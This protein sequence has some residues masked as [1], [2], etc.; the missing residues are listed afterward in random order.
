M[1][2]K[3]KYAGDVYHEE[4]DGTAGFPL[5]PA[6]LGRDPQPFMYGWCGGGLGVA[7][8]LLYAGERTG[9][10]NYRRMGVNTINF[11]VEHV[12]RDIP[13]LLFGDYYYLDK[14]WNPGR[15][16][17]VPWPDSVA[18]RQHGEN[19]DQLA[20]C[21]AWA[22]AHKMPEAEKWQKLLAEAG[23][24]LVTAERHRGMFP[25]SWF[26]DGKPAG[27]TEGKPPTIEEITTAGAYLVAPLAKLY[28]LSADKRYLDTAESALRAYYEEFGRDL[29]ISY[30]G[31]TLDA[32]AT[33]KEAGWGFMHGAIALYEVTKKQEYLDW[34]R[35]AA[36]WLLTWYVMYDMQLP[37][38][39]PLHGFVNTTGW[40]MIS[41]Q[42][43]ELDCWGQ[44]IA[45]DF[46]LLGEYLNDQRYVH[47]GR[48]LFY[49]PTQAIARP[50]AMF[51]LKMIGMELEHFNHTN[52]TYVR[53]GA[54]RGPFWGEGI[55]WALTATLYNGAKM[56]E[57]GALVW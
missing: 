30:C 3:L 2:L 44:Y 53:G 43:E 1:D 32:A 5:W 28:Q 24:F 55:L 10:A 31:A 29:R 18:A 6:C 41:V 42:N 19:L 40:T 8:G 14:K 49:A 36:D 16:A 33:D 23:D 20:D 57:L 4:P 47:V 21:I 46:Y 51:G 9:N 7:Y 45:P 54:W 17:N 34:A 39:S 12:Q 35:D 26:P 27:W 50:G 11:F 56:A 38:A 37:P 13:G 25:R 22:K 48:T 52:C 15:F